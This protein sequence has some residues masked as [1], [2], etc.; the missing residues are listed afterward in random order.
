MVVVTATVPTAL[1]T[2]VIDMDAGI[3]D[4]TTIT[5]ANLVAITVVVDWT[6]ES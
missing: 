2:M 6:D 5:V 1:R 3:L 4:V